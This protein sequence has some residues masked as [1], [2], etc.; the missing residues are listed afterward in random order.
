[1]DVATFP[2]ESGRLNKLPPELVG[3]I[4]DQADPAD[5]LDFALACKRLAAC[6]QHALRRHRDAYVK[7]RLCSDIS[8]ETVPTLSACWKPFDYMWSRDQY[9]ILPEREFDISTWNEQVDRHFTRVELEDL[10]SYTQESIGFSPSQAVRAW[11]EIQQGNDVILKMLLFSFCPRLNSLKYADP[12]EAEIDNVGSETA[13]LYHLPGIKQL[14]LH[15]G[16]HLGS[17]DPGDEDGVNHVFAQGIFALTSS[18][19]SLEHVFFDDCRLEKDGAYHCFVAAPRSLITFAARDGLVHDRRQWVSSAAKYQSKTLEAMMFYEP[20]DARHDEG[21]YTAGLHKRFENLRC[22]HFSVAKVEEAMKDPNFPGSDMRQAVA[23][24]VQWLRD[25]LPR[26][27][28]AIIFDCEWNSNGPEVGW[29]VIQLFDIVFASLV[30]SGTPHN[31][32]AAYFDRPLAYSSRA[33]YFPN[34]LEACVRYGVHIYIQGWEHETTN[35]VSNRV[36]NEHESYFPKP[37][38]KYDLLT[39]P[40]ASA[41][42]RVE[43]YSSQAERYLVT[44]AEGGRAFDPFR[45]DCVNIG[46]WGVVEEPGPV[47]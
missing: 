7:Y 30:E 22:F 23:F 28:E 35:E 10:M 8:P 3:R 37:P 44:Q 25:E 15:G 14:Y 5:H 32:K 29:N 18:C 47:V 13:F 27:A 31:N 45:G 21:V 26:S 19:S 1:M 34:S 36:S 4:L 33:S 40:Y 24:L 17:I 39:G 12:G 20:G 16:D 38:Q 42:R 43:K 41:E 9:Q 2:L 11:E 46:N 6:S